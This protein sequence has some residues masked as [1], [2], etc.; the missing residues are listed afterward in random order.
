MEERIQKIIANS[1]YCSRRKAE[2]LIKDKKVVVDG[3]VVETGFKLEKENAKITINGEKLKTQ[4]KKYYF[5]LNKPKGILVTKDD[6]QKR[7]TIYSKA[8]KS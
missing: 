7:K 8:K 2:E 1:G 6:P 4:D 5:A 3:K